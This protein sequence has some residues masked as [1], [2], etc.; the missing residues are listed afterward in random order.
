M[1]NLKTRLFADD[2][3][4]YLFYQTK[5]IKKLPSS[6]RSA[7][8]EF[9]EEI[10]K[11]VLYFAHSYHDLHKEFLNSFLEDIMKSKE[12]FIRYLKL[13]C[14]GH[15]CNQHIFDKFLNVSSLLYEMVLLCRSQGDNGF[16]FFA[17]MCWVEFFEF[18]LRKEFYLKGGWSA[19]RNHIKLKGYDSKYENVVPKINHMAITHRESSDEDDQKN[20]P[21]DENAS[22]FKLLSKKNEQIYSHEKFSSESDPGDSIKRTKHNIF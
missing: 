9:K 14:S 6:H 21:G 3:F 8:N 7:G 13:Y 10:G 17:P 19:L 22:E 12:N 2:L 4:L 5:L 20:I 11:A 18:E 1:E 15:K 16:I